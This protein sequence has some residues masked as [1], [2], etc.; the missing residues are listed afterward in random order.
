M[1]LLTATTEKLQ[2][3]TSATCTVDIYADWVDLTSAGAFSAADALGTKVT[4]ATTTDIVP[5]PGASVL[6]NVK[7]LIIHNT[8]ASTSVTVTL[9]W[10]DGTNS[11]LLE[12]CTLAP[13]ER[14]NYSEEKGLR[15]VDSLGRERTQVMQLPSGN[16]SIAAQSGFAADTYVAG[17][18]FNLGSGRIQAGSFCRWFLTITKTG[19]GTATPIFNIRQGPAGTTSDTA[20]CTFTGAIGTANADTAR[21]WIEGTFR[22]VG[23]SAV[24]QGSLEMQH[25]LAVTGFV[26]VGPAGAWMAVATS[27]SFDSTA[28]P[29]IGLSVNG[30]TSAS[31]TI[32]GC[33]LDVVNLIA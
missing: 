17:S 19:A 4:T 28:N 20:R 32:E 29:I 25:N 10:F 11:Y 27:S 13:G 1:L 21:V 3:I 31:W 12:N 26:T 8:H 33:T 9:N 6:R 2:L 18:G 30:G 5:A 15:I 14:L 16:A 7:L 23:A 24:L 22:A